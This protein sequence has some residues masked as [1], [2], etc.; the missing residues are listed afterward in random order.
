MGY[1]KVNVRI[2]GDATGDVIPA[3]LREDEVGNKTARELVD[4]VL[5]HA[6][7]QYREKADAIRA[8][9]ASNS[10]GIHDGRNPNPLPIGDPV[11]RSI[12][13]VQKDGQKLGQV[14]LIVS[15]EEQIGHR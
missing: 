6:Q 8:R 15:E 14:E 5:D 1:D 3:T 4:Y 2:V 7:G 9:L 12:R 10:A 11:V 13:E